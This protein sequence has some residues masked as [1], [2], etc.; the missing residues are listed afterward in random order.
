LHRRIR[1]EE[2][3]G[4]V[5]NQRLKTV[6]Y[7][8]HP[9]LLN[10]SV[11]EIVYDKHNSYL[12]PQA[13]PEGCPTHPAYPSSHA[14]IA[15]AGATV[16]KAFFNENFVIPNP[17]VVNSDGT[18]L[19]QYSAASLKVGGELNKLASNIAFG[20]N[21]AGIHWRSDAIEGMKLGEAVAIGVML[22]LK[23]TC[24]EQFKGFRL[25]KFDGSMVV[26]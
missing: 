19:E 4:R 3:G 6:R 18:A 8:L 13:Y 24:H 1:P 9:E 5:H 26:V 20:R 10:A 16:L 14:I 22:D 17:V 12:L 15:G 25:T 7:D 23:L 11:L 2:F 21:L